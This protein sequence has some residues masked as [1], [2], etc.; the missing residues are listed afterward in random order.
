MVNKLIIILF[1]ASTLLLAQNVEF[2]DSTMIENSSGYYWGKGRSTQEQKS[3]ELARADL[4]EKIVSFLYSSKQV[5]TISSESNGTITETDYINTYTKRFSAL[6]LS[7]LGK[8]TIPTDYGFVTWV[9]ISK[10]NWEKSLVLLAEKVEN[11][12]SQAN[13]ELTEGFPDRAISLY[14]KAYLLSYTTPKELNFKDNSGSLRAFAESSIQKMINELQLVAGTLQPDPGDDLSLLLP[15]NFR[16]AGK[17]GKSLQIYSEVAQ[18]WYEIVD[19]SASVAIEL[20]KIPKEQR[21]F[22]IKPLFHGEDFLKEIDTR[23]PLRF[24]RKVDVNFKPLIKLNIAG[25]IKNGVLSCETEAENLNVVDVDWFYGDGK[26][27]NGTVLK[28]DAA[29]Y[30][31]ITVR[32][33][34][35]NSSELEVTKTFTNPEWKEPVN[36]KPKEKEKEKPVEK[37]SEKEKPKETPPVKVDTPSPAPEV[38]ASRNTEAVISSILKVKDNESDLNA[39]LAEY[40]SMGWILV[41]KKSD[42]SDP[43]KCHIIVFDKTTGKT[44]AILEPGIKSRKDLI[45]GEVIEDIATKFKGKTPIWFQ[46]L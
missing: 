19:G 30:P 8:K 45:S 32:M 38:A 4:S 21:N 2:F 31:S 39:L 43:S 41:G 18:N 25:S 37:P 40:K 24:S 42:F 3:E 9:Y 36:E 1:F 20:P 22:E 28:A 12:I 35:N 7:G 26:K 27:F 44:V 23:Y 17:P 33:R 34:V 10:E 14:Y 46:I 16:M 29:K 15:L 6:H 11:L 13:S 5:Q